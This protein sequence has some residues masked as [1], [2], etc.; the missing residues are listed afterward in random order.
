MIEELTEQKTTQEWLDALLPLSIPIVRMNRLDDLPN[1]PHLKAV[2]FFER[3]DHPHAGPY[4]ALRPPVRFFGTPA[5][6]R[7]HPPRLGE[8][9]R[10]VLAEIGL[11]DDQI[12]ALEND[13]AA[14]EA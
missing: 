10:E 4:F 3:H 14:Q 1:D 8:Q 13:G 5:N 11:S 9:T 2:G 7:R 6:I 12:A